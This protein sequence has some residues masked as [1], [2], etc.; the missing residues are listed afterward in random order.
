MKIL[1]RGSERW[2]IKLK[3]IMRVSEEDNKEN[4]EEMIFFK[5]R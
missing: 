2:R 1:G 5:K 3:S 4:K